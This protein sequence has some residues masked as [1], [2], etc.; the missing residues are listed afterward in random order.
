MENG[1]RPGVADSGSYRHSAL[2]YKA[3]PSRVTVLYAL[4]VPAE[5]GDTL[6]A[7]TVA[8]Y[9]ALPAELRRPLHGRSS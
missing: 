6:F 9:E 4:D 8:T 5:G 2:S 3:R 7:D 1:K